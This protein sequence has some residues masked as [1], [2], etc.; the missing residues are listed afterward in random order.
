MKNK[1]LRVIREIQ[2]RLPKELLMGLMKKEKQSPT[3]KVLVERALG[4]P[5]SEVS[6]E[7]KR[8]FRAV[9]DSGFL[10]REVEVIDYDV[11]KQID[12][13]FS[14]EIEKAVKLGRLPKDPERLELLNN[15]GH[16]YARR[17]RERIK[18]LADGEDP[19]VANGPQGGAQ[20]QAE[21]PSRPSDGGVLLEPGR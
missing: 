10:D 16:Q 12:A 1:H 19:N 17:Q 14:A 3:L 11:E 6:P 20:G 21:P 13:Y 5:D 18:R 2:E 7:Q 8:R 4:K 15:K 9:I